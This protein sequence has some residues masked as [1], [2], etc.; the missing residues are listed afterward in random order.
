MQ[1][2]S[3]GWKEGIKVAGEN[4]LPRY[5]SNAYNQILLNARP[6]GVN[7]KGAPELKM[8]GFTYLRISDDL[9][10]KK[11]FKLFKTFVKRMHANQVLIPLL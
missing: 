8:F 1:V 2:L 10:E 11:N 4:A 7:K 6:Q 9:L 5:D 3:D